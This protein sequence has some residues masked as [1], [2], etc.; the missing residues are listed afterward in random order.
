M[1][2]QSGW[3]RTTQPKEWS[4]RGTLRLIRF[5]PAA[6][7][8]KHLK[9]AEDFRAKLYA[10]YVRD[11][12]GSQASGA[13]QANPGWKQWAD[14]KIA[15]LLVGIPLSARV[16]D[17][18][19]GS[20][21]LLAYLN[22]YGFRL[23]EG[24]DVSEEQVDLAVSRGLNASVADALEALRKRVG[25]YDVI[26]AFDVLE[27]F[28]KDELLQLMEA[29]RNA[30]RPNGVFIAQTPNGEGLLPGHVMYSD[31]TH[32]TILTPESLEHLLR[33]SGFVQCE[34]FET[35][36]VSKNLV[37]VV[38]T[39]LWS[40]ARGIAIALRM[41]ETGRSQRIW[42]ENMICKCKCR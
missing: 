10:H 36:P 6:R 12:K 3:G 20:G 40:I 16:L 13:Y 11:F 35:G 18:G 22:G 19:C 25:V 33:V 38:R 8:V 30:L 1:A 37:G 27:H 7:K 21:D 23:A 42:T 31:L 24:I 17:L 41:I 2:T 4:D 9:R 26:T 29:V 15:P 28:S 14:R 32:V 34:F 39:I 5:Q